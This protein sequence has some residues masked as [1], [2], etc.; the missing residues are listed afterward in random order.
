MRPWRHG[1]N[2]LDAPTNGDSDYY[3]GGRATGNNLLFDKP[4]RGENANTL[5]GTEDNPD[6]LLQDDPSDPNEYLDELNALFN[7]G[8]DPSLG[9]SAG[10]RS[11][12]IGSAA[13]A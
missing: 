4:F 12:T 9:K 6:L 2:D 13:V 3:L 10:L 1:T 7:P 5:W 11:R 8:G